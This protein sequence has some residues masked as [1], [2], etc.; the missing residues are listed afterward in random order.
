MTIGDRVTWVQTWDRNFFGN[1]EHEHRMTGTIKNID[2][3]F[4]T[5]VVP[6]GRK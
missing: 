3:E 4:I 1:P 2:N 6:D 5:V